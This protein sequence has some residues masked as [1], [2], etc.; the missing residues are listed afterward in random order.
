M[1]EKAQNVFWI[2]F[3]VCKSLQKKDLNV[4]KLCSRT[5]YSAAVS[6]LYKEIQVRSK[7]DC[8]FVASML[9][10]NIPVRSIVEKITFEGIWTYKTRTCPM[11][12]F[13]VFI[14]MLESTNLKPME[15]VKVLK[16]LQTC[17]KVLRCDLDPRH[18][19]KLFPNVQELEIQNSYLRIIQLHTVQNLKIHL[20]ETGI[21]PEQYKVISQLPLKKLMIQNY[22]DGYIYKNCVNPNLIQEFYLRGFA[23]SQENLKEFENFKKLDLFELVE[24]TGISKLESQRLKKLL[25]PKFYFVGGSRDHYSYEKSKVNK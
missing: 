15:R 11:E 17:D 4:L 2:W 5:I 16:I 24:C 22:K 18:V 10:T 3:K 12:L 9:A 20:D 14:K 23:L 13:C 1:Y 19:Q 8:L 7:E 6:Y 21:T 25:N